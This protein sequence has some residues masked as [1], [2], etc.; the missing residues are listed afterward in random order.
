MK[1]Y[2]VIQV[3]LAEIYVE[4]PV[5]IG[6]FTTRE[7]AEAAVSQIEEDSKPAGRFHNYDWN[8]EELTLDVA[9]KGW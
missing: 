8:I 7:K 5:V 2:V 9:Q 4:L 1:V 3:D 6:V